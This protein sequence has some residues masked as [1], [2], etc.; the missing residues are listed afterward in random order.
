M[1]DEVQ[2]PRKAPWSQQVEIPT[3]CPVSQ[4][5]PASW[6][7]CPSPCSAQLRGE[8]VYGGARPKQPAQEPVRVPVPPPVQLSSGGEEVYGG[9]GPKQGTLSFA[10]Q[11]RA[12]QS[13]MTIRSMKSP[14]TQ[15]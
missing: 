13:Q 2:V 8:G 7:S 4:Q 3:Q 9:A 1:C 5:Q 15:E 14:G 10:E 11:I 12:A 6:S